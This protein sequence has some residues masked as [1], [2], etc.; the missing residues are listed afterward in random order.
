MTNI[1]EEEQKR[2]RKAWIAALRSGDYKQTTRRMN[3][4]NEDGTLSYCCL[5]VAEK[6][7]NERYPKDLLRIGNGVNLGSTMALA[8]GINTFG[9]F[10]SIN[11]NSNPFNFPLYQDPNPN[12]PGI[13]KTL[14]NLNDWLRWDFNQIADFIEKNEALLTSFSGQK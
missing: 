9:R 5:G 8:L 6:I 11:D 12:G 14:T 4:P 1:T 2:N 13:S 10:Q 7:L 3:R